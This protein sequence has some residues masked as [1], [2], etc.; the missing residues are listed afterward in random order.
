MSEDLGQRTVSA[1]PA[2]TTGGSD[3]P[4]L[5]E[6]LG[7]RLRGIGQ[8]LPLAELTRAADR[9]RGATAACGHIM[10]ESGHAEWMGQL[11]TAG[12]H[13]DSAITATLA[14]LDGLDGYLAGIGLPGVPRD[15]ARRVAPAHVRPTRAGATPRDDAA[16][17]VRVWWVERVDL[18]TDHEP[19]PERPATVRSDGERPDGAAPEEPAEALRRLV[20]AARG[21]RDGYRAELLRTH[22]A[23]G[24]QLATPGARAFRPLAADL[25]GHAPG[26]DDAKALAE[27]CAGRVREL[28]PRIPA[29]LPADLVGEL[30]DPYGGRSGDTGEP[31]HPVDAAASWPV[32][33]A[34]LLRALGRDDDEVTRLTALAEQR[35]DETLKRDGR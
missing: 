19:E 10:A 35:T 20:R 26:G 7:A 3:R 5:V 30:C 17:A 13:L 8:D 22:P 25:L 11:E 12:T 29:A 34:E 9:L 21:G 28:L 16:L 23:S 2:R 14:V 4:S 6:S 1:A 32:L 33:V 24:L 31:R 15:G 27:R 18:L